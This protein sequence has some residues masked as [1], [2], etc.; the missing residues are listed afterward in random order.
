MVMFVTLL[1]VLKLFDFFA[2]FYNFCILLWI[3]VSLTKEKRNDI[4]VVIE[5]VKCAKYSFNL[6]YNQESAKLSLLNTF[7]SLL[8][9][10]YAFVCLFVWVFFFAIFKDHAPIPSLFFHLEETSLGIHL[11]LNSCSPISYDVSIWPHDEWVTGIS[12]PGV[13]VARC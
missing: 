1:F 7:T 6:T 11:F 2:N 10:F 9:S 5:K 13:R 3:F 4:F 12:I 8:C